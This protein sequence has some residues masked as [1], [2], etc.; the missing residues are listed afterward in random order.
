M[1]A[2]KI[3]DKYDSEWETVALNYV[4]AE[5]EV[6]VEISTN[7]AKQFGFL[8]S[9]L[10]SE[11][12]KCCGKC[13]RSYESFEDFFYGTDAIERGTVNYPSIGSEFYLH[14]NCKDSCG[15]TLVVVFNDRRD[16]SEIGNQRR[17]VFQ[18]CLEIL[19]D[20]MGL[21]EMEA[22]NILFKLLKERFHAEE[23]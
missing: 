3:D 18:N 5:L 12:P 8:N 2:R 22:R 15:S 13:G 23:A 4:R 7:M 6:F 10:K 17:Q 11:F 14:R 9:R 19:A 21:A 1:Y 20:K 16:D